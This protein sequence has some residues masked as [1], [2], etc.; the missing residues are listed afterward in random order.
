ML[1]NKLFLL[2]LTAT[3]MIANILCE[4]DVVV[5]KATN[6][7]ESQS[8]DVNYMNNG[9]S[10]SSGNCPVELDIINY[11]RV[12]LFRN[13]EFHDEELIGEA[14]YSS[15]VENHCYS[16]NQLSWFSHNINLYSKNEDS[17]YKIVIPFKNG[18][19]VT[20]SS[21]SVNLQ[22]SFYIPAIKIDNDLVGRFY[23]NGSSVKLVTFG[24]DY[25]NVSQSY[26]TFGH[27]NYET[28]YETIYQTVIYF[29]FEIQ[30]SYK[31]NISNI[32]TLDIGSFRDSE[33]GYGEIRTYSDHNYLFDYKEGYI[34]YD[35]TYNYPFFYDSNCMVSPYDITYLDLSGGDADFSLG[36]SIYGEVY[37]SSRQVLRLVGITFA[38]NYKGINPELDGQGFLQLFNM[39]RSDY[40]NW[41]ND[42]NFE[43]PINEFVY[44]SRGRYED[45]VGGEGSLINAFYIPNPDLSNI[46]DTMISV[47][48]MTFINAGPT[49]W[50]SSYDP[51]ETLTDQGVSYS[52]ET[53]YFPYNIS[54]LDNVKG[55]SFAYHGEDA[56]GYCSQ[57]T[58]GINCSN[59][60]VSTYQSS[61]LTYYVATLL[62]PVLGTVVVYAADY[63]ISGNISKGKNI[64]RILFNV[65]DSRNQII[66]NI[67]KIQFCYQKGDREPKV[68]EKSSNIYNLKPY[69]DLTKHVVEAE[70]SESL[71]SVNSN[72]WRTVS[73][74]ENG[75][76]A[77]DEGEHYRVGEYDYRYFYQN[78]YDTKTRSDFMCYWSLLSVWYVKPS[79]TTERLTTSV[80]GYY[81]KWDDETQDWVVVSIDNPDVDSGITVEEFLNGDTYGSN[82]GFEG[83]EDNS[84]DSFWNGITD[85]IIDFGKWF[86]IANAIILGIGLIAGIIYLI[87]R[88]GGFLGLGGSKSTTTI[89]LNGVNSAKKS[90]P[91]KKKHKRKKGK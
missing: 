89:N 21:M 13:C 56:L 73:T 32:S 14:Y 66:K 6:G 82:E 22:T 50:V 52:I 7:S 70:S 18:L 16:Q 65:Y 4:R 64:Q 5:A 28:H 68:D 53:Y 47:Y 74:Q 29:N 9:N 60:R 17:S 41:I 67:H 36:N 3:S 91:K 80:D 34:P 87:I 62:V 25:L 42:E 19:F 40:N 69:S 76:M 11:N 63:V 71:L 30:T 43:V 12:N 61:P 39:G 27:C 88:F 44:L 24:S 54:S 49:S 86:G 72:I 20:L 90:K 57:R 8:I 45:E 38:V 83:P 35:S 46:D 81:L 15:L 37:G 2:T 48:S 58:V 85:G 51:R 79:G 77:L 31:K 1:F 33:D 75:F 23:V 55:I 10:W 84:W 59:E 26:L 78:I